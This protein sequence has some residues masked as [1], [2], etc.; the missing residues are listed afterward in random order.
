[1]INPAL[2]A[3]DMPTA[4]VSEEKTGQDLRNPVRMK[5][6]NGAQLWLALGRR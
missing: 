5:G 3:R 2:I 6:V 1:V 4:L